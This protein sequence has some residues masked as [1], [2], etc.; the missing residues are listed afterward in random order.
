MKL[1]K[2][3]KTLIPSYIKRF[4]R[5]RTQIKQKTLKK[6]IFHPIYIKININSYPSSSIQPKLVNY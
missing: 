5:R 4:R 2:L 3:K 1:K 6:Y